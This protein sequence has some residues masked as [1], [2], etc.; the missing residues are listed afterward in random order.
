MDRSFLLLLPALLIG[1][2][3]PN[4]KA[5][6]TGEDQ[7]TNAC[8]EEEVIIDETIPAQGSTSHYYMADLEFHLSDPDPT[9]A[10]IVTDIPGTQMESEDGEIIYWVLDAPLE[11]STSYCATLEY[12]GG[13]AEI[14]FSTSALGTPLSDPQIL[15]DRTYALD[16]QNARIV[17]PEG[18]GSVLT[19]Y[20]TQDILVGVASIE[21][22]DI[23]MNGAIGVEGADPPAQDYC[24]PTIAFPV[25]DFSASPYFQIGPQTTTLSVAG[26][27][28]E[29]QDL[30]ITG[31]F[32]SD[33]SYFGGG[34][35]SGT[36]DTR[37]L[38]G[39]VDDS[40]NPDPNTI[41]DLATSFG[42][43][44][45]DCSDGEPYC[46]TLVADQI[47]ADE[48]SGLTIMEVGGNDCTGCETW[49]QD[50]VPAV[51]AQE[52]P[53]EDTGE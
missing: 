11:P 37:P 30:E 21:G 1:C 20:L 41:C 16:L 35:L 14:C 44:C 29:I 12:C 9:G 45:V 51:E 42:A 49:T 50:T 15:V 31:T 38:V 3:G 19:S 48:V 53:V 46:L 7:D 5:D 39:L 17:V 24:D 6:D 52:C 2:P 8:G 33:G 36:I 4:E 47:N 27:E 28:I 40:T 18:I 32:A 13:D 43:S 34:T 22:S 23:Q 10:T 25:A 26:F